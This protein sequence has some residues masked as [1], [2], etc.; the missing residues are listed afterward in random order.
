MDVAA[1]S[2]RSK[3]TVTSLVNRWTR[4]LKQLFGSER[5]K[6]REVRI[7][8]FYTAVQVST[9]HLGVAFTPRG[10]TD[11]VCCPKS[12]ASAPPA[13]TLA[14]RD[15]WET[16]AFA[17]APTP[18]R[19]A[20]GIATLNAL[21]ALAM[22]RYGAAGGQVSHGLDALEA[23]EIRPDDVVV[24]VGAFTPFLKRLKG[25][26][27]GLF[28]IDS[29]PESLKPEELGIWRSPYQA[30]ETLAEA[31][32]VIISGS[33]LVEDE[34]DKLLSAATRARRIVLAGPTAS[35]WPP[36]FFDAGVDVLGGIRV[37]DAAKM[38]QIV[39]EGGSGYFFGDAAEKISIVRAGGGSARRLAE[40]A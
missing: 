23:A 13:G 18:L 20:V 1:N 7:G 39:A 31:S 29:H 34:L 6:I 32:V 9:G 26:V 8:V 38:L 19:R 11:T 15:V 35:P 30:A 12:A 27:A 28:V 16:A 21:S 14:G 40:T 2:P 4:E 24:M 25:R 17:L 33:A 5:L 36:P 10:L 37:L 22:E 3:R